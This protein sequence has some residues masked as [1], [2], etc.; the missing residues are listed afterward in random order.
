MVFFYYW[1]L[2]NL[3]LIAFTLLVVC[4]DLTVS[5][6]LGVKEK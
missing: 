3:I 6:I 5:D 2:I 4:K 1:L